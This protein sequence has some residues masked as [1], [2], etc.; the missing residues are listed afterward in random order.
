MVYDQSTPILVVKVL[1]PSTA[2]EDTVR[3]STEYL[4][5]GIKQYS[6]INRTGESI[7]AYANEGK[8]WAQVA[9]LDAENPTAMPS[10]RLGVALDLESLLQP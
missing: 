7:V 1:S 5:A 6:M 4:A 10:R 3:K 9:V 8:A 2:S